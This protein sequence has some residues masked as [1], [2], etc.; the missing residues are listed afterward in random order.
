MYDIVKIIE[1]VK[2][3]YESNNHLRILKDFERVLDELDL[4]V[5]ENWTKGE[6]VE[7]PIVDRHTVTCSFM[8]PKAE[9][10]N[11]RAG[12]RLLEYNCK[13]S[14]A[15][16]FMVQP[17]KIKS[18]DDYRP[19]TKKGKLDRHPIWIVK[20]SMPKSLMFDMYKGY[21]RSIDEDLY[22]DMEQA[23]TQPNIN[24]EAG[25]DMESADDLAEI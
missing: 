16:D 17:R 8:W 6:L 18:P 12:E 14:Y 24:P 5:F 11:P 9:M 25:S 7:G 4:Y 10:P 20:I 2:T 23:V 1:N 22:G 15:K 21:L 3:I 19:G 13:V